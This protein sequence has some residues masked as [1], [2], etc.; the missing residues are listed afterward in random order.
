MLQIPLKFTKHFSS[1]VSVVTQ[2]CIMEM[3]KAKERCFQSFKGFTVII[4]ALVH[5][6]STVIACDAW[7][8]I[9]AVL[10][11]RFAD[12]SEKPISFVFRVLMDTE[13]INLQVEK[14]G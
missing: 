4:T 2:V 6:D 13:K 3:R 12:G 5:F 9:S 7:L 14:K 10:S 8:M 1:I 11:Y